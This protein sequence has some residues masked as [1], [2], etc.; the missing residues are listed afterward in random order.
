MYVTAGDGIPAYTVEGI[1]VYTVEGIPVY[2]VEGIPAYTIEGI[3]AYT[4]AHC[5]TAMSLP[6]VDTTRESSNRKDTDVTWEE[7]PL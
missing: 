7:C 1:P 4:T 6:P 2:T 5:I 3:P